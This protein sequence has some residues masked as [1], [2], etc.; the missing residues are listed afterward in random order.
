MPLDPLAT[1]ASGT[2]LC[3]DTTWTATSVCAKVGTISGSACNSSTPS[4]CSF[5]DKNS[6][7]KGFSGAS[8]YNYIMVVRDGDGNYRVPQVQRYRSP[9]LTGDFS[10]T[11]TATFRTEQRWRRAAPFL[12]D[13]ARQHSATNQLQA[14][15]QTMVYVPMDSSGLD[16]DFFMHKYE[17]S[18]Y[19]G[20]ASNGSPD[21]TSAYP[22]QA[23]AGGSTW[24][25]KAGSC[26]DLLQ[27]TGSF[28]AA[29]CGDGSNVNASSGVLQSKQA[30]TPQVSI[31][32]GVFWKECANTGIT[33]GSNN[34]YYERLPTDSEWMKAA[35]WGD[36]AQ[37]GTVTNTQFAGAL[38]SGVG[39]L[40]STTLSL[41]GD[42]SGTTISNISSTTG[43]EVGA[44]I[45]STSY[46]NA[47][48]TV[49][50][51]VNATTI[52]ISATPAT[53][54]IGRPLTI[55][56]LGNCNTNNLLAVA[57]AGSTTANCRSR[58]GA[59]DMVG[60]VWEWTSGQHYT[61]AGFDNG[62]DGLW[63][64]RT[65][66]TTNNASFGT[67]FD[68]LRGFARSSGNGAT[69][70]NNGDYQWYA[71]TLRGAIRGGAWAH[72]SL[73]GRWSLSVNIAP[74]AVSSSIGGRCGR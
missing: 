55:Q 11:A 27:R 64:G 50:S 54:G 31:D 66:T 1:D 59:A 19:T 53:N 43:I 15:P 63:T 56:T 48:T 34:V 52:T 3:K 58:Y 68:L 23:L 29:A 61:A 65:L 20:A 13:E 57:S 22:L 32:Q 47:G 72:G 38:G 40:E 18:L 36:V 37:Q 28:N 42:I 5:V 45:Q 24:T 9:Y 4:G 62:V 6:T 46:I 41:T 25:N 33:D 73:G 74:S 67:I 70:S 51:V 49:A 14:N 30:T 16:H 21:A 69:V 44:Y 60:N 17:A 71:S 39:A 26:F 8:I 35:A 10:S 12:V 2:Q 7:N